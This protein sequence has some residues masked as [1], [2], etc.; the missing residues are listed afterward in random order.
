ME[1]SLLCGVDVLLL[2]GDQSLQD[3]LLFDSA[4]AQA[5]LT[6]LPF[7]PTKVAV[8]HSVDVRSY[9]RLSSSIT[10]FTAKLLDIGVPR[11]SGVR[12][13]DARAEPKTDG[14]PERPMRMFP[15]PHQN[16]SEGTSL[17]RPTCQILRSLNPKTS[18]AWT[19]TANRPMTPSST[20]TQT[21]RRLPVPS[22]TSHTNSR[23]RLTDSSLNSR[24]AV[25]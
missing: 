1:L 2:V 7:A 12:E 22:R 18:F 6:T 15:S 3:F 5:L 4:N 10:R 8:H 19:P 13:T 21:S 11:V 20:K 25:L 14:S 24:R 9:P 16:A 17:P 23:P